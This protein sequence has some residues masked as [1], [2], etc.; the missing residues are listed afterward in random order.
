[1]TIST[2]QGVQALVAELNRAGELPAGLGPLLEEVPREKFIPDREQ[3]GTDESVTEVVPW[4]FLGTPSSRWALAVAMPQCRAEIEPSTAERDYKLGWLHDPV[5]GSWASLVPLGN[6]KYLVRQAGIR[7]L[8]DEAAAVHR[9]WTAKGEPFITD[10][11]WTITPDG[12]SI[13]VP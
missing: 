10:W 8:W 9:W 13:S 6:G 5:S 7:R 12:Q 4:P 1:M 3:D 2:E 11:I